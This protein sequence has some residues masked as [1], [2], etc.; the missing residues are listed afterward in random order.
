MAGGIFYLIFENN[1]IISYDIIFGRAS[2]LV[3]QNDVSAYCHVTLDI[4]G[5]MVLAMK[6]IISV[7]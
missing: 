2:T 5:E 1:L 7:S 3:P 6:F 4:D